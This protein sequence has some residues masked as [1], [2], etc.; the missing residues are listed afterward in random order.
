MTR[1]ITDGAVLTCSAGTGPATFR[2]IPQGIGGI[3]QER[4]VATVD[5]VLPMANI[6]SFGMCRTRGIPCV[7]AASPWVPGA[8]TSRINGKPVATMTCK[9]SCAHGGIISAVGPGAAVYN[10]S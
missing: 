8:P 1:A 3:G 5:Q 6:P 4:Q 9:C 2:A 10:A 7:P